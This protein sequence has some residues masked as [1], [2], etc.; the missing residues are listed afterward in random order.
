MR[1]SKVF[2]GIPDDITHIWVTN[3]P[4]FSIEKFQ[5]ESMEYE[6]NGDI[7][8]K[9]IDSSIWGN[10]IKARKSGHEGKEWYMMKKSYHFT[11][12]E[13]ALRLRD[14]YRN[15]NNEHVNPS[16][17]RVYNDADDKE[18][19]LANIEEFMSKYP[20]MTI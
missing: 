11:E 20:E 4:N 15:L 17:S 5:I 3:L 8:I 16:A 12:N 1:A 19:T 6:K 7:T 14:H 10:T 18:T 13:A 9:L 2:S